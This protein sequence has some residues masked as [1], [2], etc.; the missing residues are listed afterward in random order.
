MAINFPTSPALNDTV[1]DG[2]TTWK[3]VAVGPPPVWDIVPVASSGGGGAS[4]GDLFLLGG[5]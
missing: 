2:T 1:T 3:C 4:F 5:M